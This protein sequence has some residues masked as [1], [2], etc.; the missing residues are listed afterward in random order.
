VLIAVIAVVVILVVAVVVVAI[1]FVAVIVT[2]VLF[3]AFQG[4]RSVDM[5]AG[6][7]FKGHVS[8]GS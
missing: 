8:T 6:S 7:T 5:N 3:F 4:V 1:V 2:T